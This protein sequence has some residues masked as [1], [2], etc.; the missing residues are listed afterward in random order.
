LSPRRYPLQSLKLKTM[1]ALFARQ[2]DRRCAALA[3]AAA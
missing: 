2:F 3:R 1:A